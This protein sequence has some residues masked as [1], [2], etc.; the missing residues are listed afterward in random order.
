MSKAQRHLVAHFVKSLHATKGNPETA[1][2]YAMAQNWADA[3]QV[4]C[5][6]KA[7]AGAMTTAD[8]GT[9][10]VSVDFSAAVRARSIVGRL[11]AARRIPPL[12]RVLSNEGKSNAG[13]VAQGAPIRVG[14]LDLAGGV[15]GELR[16]SGIGVLG[17]ELLQSSSPQA[18]VILADDLA[19]SCAEAVGLVMINVLNISAAADTIFQAAF[20]APPRPTQ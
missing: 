13:F 7:V 20:T 15:L 12:C 19:A 16:V 8:F 3:H 14:K 2:A 11:T 10:N 6:I 18:D 5:D 17:I 4:A 1:A 9:T